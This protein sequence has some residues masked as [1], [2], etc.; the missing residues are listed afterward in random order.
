[1]KIV[2]VIRRCIL[3]LFVL[4]SFSILKA[5]KPRTAYI[6]LDGIVKKSSALSMHIDPLG[7]MVKVRDRHGRVVSLRV[8]DSFYVIQG[9]HVTFEDSI[10][11]ASGQV[12]I[13]RAMAEEILSEFHL[14]IQYDLSSQKVTIQKNSRDS[15]IKKRTKK[16]SSRKER[17]GIAPSKGSAR[18]LSFIVIDPGH[19]GKDPGAH[20]HLGA[21]EKK[22]TLKVARSLYYTLKKEFPG[23]RVYITRFNDKFI[24]LEKRSEIANRKMNRNGFGIFLSVH[25]NATLSTRT[26]GYEIYYLSQ[27]ASNE[28]SRKV[29]LRENSSSGNSY[30]AKLESFLMHSQIQSESKMLARQ[31]NRSFLANLRSL[32]SSRGVKRADFAVLRGALMPAVLIEMGY[33]TNRTEAGVLRSKRFRVGFAQALVKAIR[34]FQSSIPTL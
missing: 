25:C 10:E 30:V 26:R 2:L 12:M 3:V 14:P 7:L 34:D 33:L 22:I 27:N 13:P 23:V 15:F 6:S 29:M 28:E 31:I 11:V 20:G 19:G 8:G 21:V 17:P 9:N 1:M 18:K 32:V 5:A 24:S 16:Y 4:V